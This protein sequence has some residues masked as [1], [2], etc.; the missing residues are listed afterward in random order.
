MVAMIIRDKDTKIFVVLYA[1]LVEFR[2]EVA[3]D[4]EMGLLPMYAKQQQMP[5]ARRILEP[6]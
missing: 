3:P 1:R 4:Y 6:F 2:T 5:S